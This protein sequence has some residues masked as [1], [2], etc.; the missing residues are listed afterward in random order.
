MSVV[1]TVAL[2]DLQTA[3]GIAGPAYATAVEALAV[4]LSR[5]GAV[6]LRLPG[7]VHGAVLKGGLAAMLASSTR[8]L[9]GCELRE[10]RVGGLPDPTAIE[11]VR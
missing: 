5:H 6:V 3:T 9:P 2:T 7:K 11:E 10:W 4:A 8:S 1:P